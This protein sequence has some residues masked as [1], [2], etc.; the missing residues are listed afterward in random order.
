MPFSKDRIKF[1]RKSAGLVVY[2]DFWNAMLDEIESLQDSLETLDVILSKQNSHLGTTDLVQCRLVVEK[3][4]GIHE[5]RTE[6][7]RR[8]NK[9]GSKP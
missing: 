9:T 3:A 2:P 4:L 5:E 6:Q 8:Q 7:R 1:L